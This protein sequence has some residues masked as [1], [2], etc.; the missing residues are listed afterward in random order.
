M[1][2]SL[3]ESLDTMLQNTDFNR[4]LTNISTQLESIQ[5]QLGSSLHR[6]QQVMSQGF[7]ANS[8][9]FVH[10]VTAFW[11]LPPNEL[12]QKINDAILYIHF[13]C[14]SLQNVINIDEWNAEY[15]PRDRLR[16]NG[17]NEELRALSNRIQMVH[18]QADIV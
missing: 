5:R 14:E 15:T 7:T 13:K 18:R 3:R 12:Q 17:I 4:D 6:F 8:L 11:H 16:I 1:N 2:T 10:Y 9:D